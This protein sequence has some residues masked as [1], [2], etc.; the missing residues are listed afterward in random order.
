MSMAGDGTAGS[1][2]PLG[3]A[4]TVSRVGDTQMGAGEADTSESVGAMGSAASE[5]GNKF[6]I[7]PIKIYFLIWSVAHLRHNIVV[8][9][10]AM[11]DT[12]VGLLLS[13]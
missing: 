5:G 13:C 2:G 9:A 10:R 12:V 3:S 4:G 6:F 11:A 8:S 1:F 7:E